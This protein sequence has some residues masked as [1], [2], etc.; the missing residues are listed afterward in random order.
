[1][2]GGF[3]RNTHAFHSED[4]KGYVGL[5]Y[6]LI[7]YYFIFLRY[8]L[9]ADAII[10][11]DTF[12][13]QLASRLASRFSQWKRYTLLLFEKLFIILFYLTSSIRL[14]PNLQ[15]FMKEQLNRILKT[16]NVS[17]ECYEIC[18]KTLAA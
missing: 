10:S 1:L 2:Y 5:I 9:Y 14:R 3:A 11:I 4:G 7:K 17:K 18:V 13:N 16:P 12:N 15:S 6:Y 8:A